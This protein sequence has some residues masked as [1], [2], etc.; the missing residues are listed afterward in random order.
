MRHSYE[1]ITASRGEEA[2]QRVNDTPSIEL[3]LMD[4]ELPGAMDGANTARNILKQRELPIVFLTGH[5]ED[6]YTHKVE[7]ITAYGYVVKGTGEPP[8][9][10]SIRIA[11]RLFD[12]MQQSREREH[13][14]RKMIEGLTEGIWRLDAKG[15]TV[16]ANPACAELLGSSVKEMH[17]THFAEYIGEREYEEAAGLLQ[18]PAG[19][20]RGG[21]KVTLR[22]SDRS[23]LPAR[24]SISALAAEDGSSD[25]FIVAVADA[26]EES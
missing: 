19:E 7:G 13:A 11:Q 20:R 5:T 21:Y 9:M 26:A 25:G 6:S 1:V 22:R 23:L 4:L 15:Y 8:L 3:V 14:W 24:L 17:G 12:A 10:E 18:L 16:Y 2:L